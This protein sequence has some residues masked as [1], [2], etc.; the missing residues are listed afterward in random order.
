MN[1][2]ACV[3]G[4]GVGPWHR[5]TVGVGPA[6]AEA[7]EAEARRRRVSVSEVIRIA[8]QEHL[9]RDAEHRVIPLLEEAMA[10]HVD[11]LAALIAKAYFAAAVAA[12]QANYLIAVTDNKADPV[13]IMR[14]ANIRARVDMN[15][16]G[17]EIGGAT[18]EEYQTAVDAV[19]ERAARRKAGE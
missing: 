11:R 7:I 1:F 6:D 18:E 4:D 15:R 5:Y 12:W 8:I 19:R 10:P 9:A 13:D 3:G 14:E 16:K 2:G 17:S